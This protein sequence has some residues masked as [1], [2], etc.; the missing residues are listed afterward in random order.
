MMFEREDRHA[1]DGAAG[2]HVEHAEDAACCVLKICAQAVGI[3]AG[4]RNV[5]AEAIDEQRAE[6]EPDAL[7]QLL[8]LGEGR[9]IEIGGKLFGRGCHS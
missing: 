2:E 1:V 9:E 6:G 7:L 4:Q 8:G 3:D 5:G